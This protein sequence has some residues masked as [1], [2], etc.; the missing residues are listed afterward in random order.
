M[1]VRIFAICFSIFL[2]S[3]TAHADIA[4]TDPDQFAYSQNDSRWKW[5]DLGDGYKTIGEWGCYMT[6]LAMLATA[7]GHKLNPGE[8]NDAFF[9]AGV[10]EPKSNLPPNALER[11][12]PVQFDGLYSSHMSIKN[13]NA[14]DSDFYNMIIEDWYV[15][16]KM[17]DERLMNGEVMLA[18]VDNTPDTP[19]AHAKDQHWVLIWSSSKNGSQT[20]YSAIDPKNGKNFSISLKYGLLGSSAEQNI[21]AVIFYRPIS[22]AVQ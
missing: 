6:N 18:M 9:D 7:Y 15:L 14:N 5:D 1:Q 11:I 21:K 13:D 4:L 22:S 17:I 10:F 16:Q 8:L 20:E 19:Y 12:M 2:Y 3:T